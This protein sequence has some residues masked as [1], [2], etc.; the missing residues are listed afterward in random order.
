[1]PCAVRIGEHVGFDR[2]CSA[3]IPGLHGY[4]VSWKG[5]RLHQF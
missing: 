4:T 1:V 3:E 2:L 5:G